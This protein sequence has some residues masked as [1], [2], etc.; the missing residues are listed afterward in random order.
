M[1]LGSLHAAPQKVTPKGERSGVKPAG[2]CARDGW[3]SPA[4]TITLGYP[5]LAGGLGPKLAGK[6]TA[7]NFFPMEL[8]PP[9]AAAAWFAATQSAISG[10]QAA[11]S[12]SGRAPLKRTSK[13]QVRVSSR[14]K[15]RSAL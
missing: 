15:A 10:W 6:R 4:G 11:G 1:S 14:S 8:R 5:A 2:S 9:A 12:A 13:P 3:K 7:S